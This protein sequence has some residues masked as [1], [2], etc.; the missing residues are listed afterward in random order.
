[1]KHIGTSVKTV[2]VDN[3]SVV[4]PGGLS[5]ELMTESIEVKLRGPTEELSNLTGDSVKA[6]LELDFDKN[7][8]VTGSSS[9]PLKITVSG[10]AGVYEI[11]DYSAV[12]KINP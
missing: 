10:A 9:V 4:N 12:V 7:K 5:Y 2:T 3:I 6:T 8:K 11:G 1:M